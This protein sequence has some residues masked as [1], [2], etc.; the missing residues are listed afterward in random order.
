[1]NML[2]FCN[3]IRNLSL[4]TYKISILR[5]MDFK[6]AVSQ[7]LKWN[8]RILNFFAKM[9]LKRFLRAIFEFLIKKTSTRL[10]AS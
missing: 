4:F 10:M 7:F 9:S 1:M 8:L 5:C 3:F 2:N 6:I